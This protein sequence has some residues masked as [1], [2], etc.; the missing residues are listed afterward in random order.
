[1]VVYREV[2]ALPRPLSSLNGSTGKHCLVDVDHFVSL[3]D[4]GVQVFLQL[5]LECRQLCFQVGFHHLFVQDDLL[6]NAMP[7]INLSQQRPVQLGEGVARVDVTASLLQRE[8]YLL[9]EG[10]LVGNVLLHRRRHKSNPEALQPYIRLLDRLKC[11]RWLL[12]LVEPC[13]HL[14]P[15]SSLGDLHHRCQSAIGDVGGV[16][17]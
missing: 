17:A 15:D 11:A 4:H 9:L 2:G 8:T 7:L 3:S 1:M 12:Q 10:A 5:R 6:L 16:E 13:D 14:L